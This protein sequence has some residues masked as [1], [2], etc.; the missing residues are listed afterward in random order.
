M[1]HFSLKAM[2]LYALVAF[3]TVIGASFALLIRSKMG[4]R[5]SGVDLAA[6]LEDFSLDA[7]APLERLLNDH[8]DFLFLEN[9]PGFQPEIGIALRR[10]RRAIAREYLHSLTNDFRRL[11]QIA[12][13]M[14]VYSKEDNSQLAGSI[15]RREARFY[16]ALAI[17]HLSLAGYP[18][19]R[20][21]D[22]GAV[23]G[24]LASLYHGIQPERAAT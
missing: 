17:T 6:W 7:Y 22:S 8:R 15:W 1:L 16:S 5:D 9:H 12:K 2:L 21:W 13:L 3:V 18:L 11:S 24:Q 19:A 10:E 4:D 20:R 23:L 14:L